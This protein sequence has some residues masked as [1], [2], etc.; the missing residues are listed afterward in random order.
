MKRYLSLA[1][2]ISVLALGAVM[3]FAQ[4]GTPVDMGV[5]NFGG[6]VY[7]WQGLTVNK[8]VLNGTTMTTTNAIASNIAVANLTNALIGS[9]SLG[10]VVITNKC[11]GSTNVLY[12]SAV[13][14]R[15]NWTHTP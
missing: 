15:T 9:T 4:D 3:L 10:A 7:C 2:V 6:P 11:N 1:V 8:I 5:K 13:G 14:T 12:Y